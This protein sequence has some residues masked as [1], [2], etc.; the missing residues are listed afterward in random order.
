[1]QA[2]KTS[3][4]K[5]P[6]CSGTGIYSQRGVCFACNGNGAYAADPLSRVFGASGEFFGVSGPAANGTVYKG[7][8][9][10]ANAEELAADLIQGYTFKPI[11][12]EQARA[13]FK[14]YGASTRV[15]A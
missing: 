8:V 7:I 3:Y 12:E 15:A 11:S 4:K 9:R 10:A 5:C 13:F 1:M 14:R 2:T 6:R